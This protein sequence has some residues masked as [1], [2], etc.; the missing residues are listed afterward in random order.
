LAN[1][2]E[3]KEIPP[4]EKALDIC[5]LALE[6]K[7]DDVVML[8]MQRVSSFCDYF[9]I[10]SA[11]SFKKTRA[12]ADHIEASL[13]RKKIKPYHVE[14]RGD[15]H[16]ILLDYGDVVVHVLYE[17]ARDFYGLE[18]LWGDAKHIDVSP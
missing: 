13:T 1:N 6:K 5:N 4:K 14:G 10:T 17:E 3:V 11:G 18:R 7:A 12:I 15:G 2:A 16:W 8:D 9:V